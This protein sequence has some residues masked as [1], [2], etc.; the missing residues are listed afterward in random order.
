MTRKIKPE[1]AL[2]RACAEWVAFKR[3]TDPWYKLVFSVQNERRVSAREGALWNLRGRQK[4]V[5]DWIILC[6][7]KDNRYTGAALELKSEKGRTTDAQKE[8]LDTA[9]GH[10]NFCAVIRSFDA[11]QKII[12][13]F[14]EG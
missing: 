13:Y 10:G 3:K 7:S 2:T 4:G 12:T 11:F 6:A 9:Y 1:D 8:F 5:S 14:K